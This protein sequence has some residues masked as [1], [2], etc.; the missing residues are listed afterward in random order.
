MTPFVLGVILD[1]TIDELR[2]LDGDRSWDARTAQELM[3]A[4]ADAI[5]E[6]LMAATDHA[7]L[8]RIV[9]AAVKSAVCEAQSI[10]NKGRRR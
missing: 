6:R 2:P 7:E 3:R 4:E 1:A 9:R 8:R 10:A 5:I